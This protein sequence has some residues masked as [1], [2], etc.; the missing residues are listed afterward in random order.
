MKKLILISCFF[1]FT[2]TVITS[3]VNTKKKEDVKEEVV[4]ETVY[5]CPMDCEN[6]KTYA[7]P[8][9]CPKCEMD[10]KA[11]QAEDAK[12]EHDQACNCLDG[13]EC[14]CPEGECTCAEES[15][16]MAKNCMM[17]DGECSC[18]MKKA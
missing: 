10:L 9:K 2:G 13:E 4:T 3:C 8:G 6:G 14:T 16:E 17:C 12:H 7:E 1:L 11:Q 5:Q 18:G 15:E